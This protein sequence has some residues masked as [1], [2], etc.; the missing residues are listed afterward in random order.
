MW[1][2]NIKPSL[3]FTSAVVI[4]LL[5]HSHWQHLYAVVFLSLPCKPPSRSQWDLRQINAKRTLC[6][7][8]M[9]IECNTYHCLS[10]VVKNTC[11]VLLKC[12]PDRPLLAIIGAIA[13]KKMKRWQKYNLR[14]FDTKG[15]QPCRLLLRGQNSRPVV[16]FKKSHSLFAC[17]RQSWKKEKNQTWVPCS[18]V[19]RKLMKATVQ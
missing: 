3:S 19:C 6:T 17:S 15:S 2:F 1:S 14:K 12:I 13:L 10:P 5:Y 7:K 11:V 16:Y 9:F 18:L 8:A 4:P